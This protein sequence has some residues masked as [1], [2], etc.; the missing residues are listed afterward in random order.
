MSNIISNTKYKGYYVGN[1]KQMFT[2]EEYKRHIAEA[3][4][5][6]DAAVRDASSGMITLEFVAQYI[7][8]ITVTITDD[9][10]TNLNI[11]I[12]TGKNTEKWLAKLA[13]HRADRTDH[14]FKIMIRYRKRKFKDIL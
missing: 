5:H 1:K 13:A 10:T 2:K 12:F 7:D 3:K 8:K 6:L 4:T 11:K 9:D 14:T